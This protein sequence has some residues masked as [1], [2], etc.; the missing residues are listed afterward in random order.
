MK[1]ASPEPLSTFPDGDWMDAEPTH[2]AV[3]TQPVNDATQE[4]DIRVNNFPPGMNGLYPGTDQGSHPRPS[5][6]PDDALP[7]PRP[8]TPE[9]GIGEVD[10]D[11]SPPEIT[12]SPPLPVNPPTFD[13]GFVDSN[14][15]DFNDN[16]N[17]STIQLGGPTPQIPGPS[18]PQDDIS[19]AGSSELGGSPPQHFAGPLPTG[20]SPSRLPSPPSP[21]SY[22]RPSPASPQSD[23]S[24]DAE[25]PSNP[26]GVTKLPNLNGPV[27][28]SSLVDRY[29]APGEEVTGEEEKVGDLDYTPEDEVDYGDSD[30]ETTEEKLPT[31]DD[32]DNMWDSNVAGEDK[33]DTKMNEDSFTGI[34][35]SPF[36]LTASPSPE[37]YNPPY[38]GAPPQTG[39]PDNAQIPMTSPPWV[40]PVIVPSTSPIR[41]DIPHQQPPLKD[42]GYIPPA[43]PNT[44]G[45]SGRPYSQVNAGIRPTDLRPVSDDGM[46]TDEDDT[47]GDADDNANEAGDVNDVAPEADDTDV[48]SEGSENARDRYVE[49]LKLEWRVETLETIF[50]EREA[51]YESSTFQLDKL[52][53]EVAEEKLEKEK[54]LLKYWE[55]VRANLGDDDRGIKYK[56]AYLYSP[57]TELN[58]EIDAEANIR[59]LTFL[60]KKA[61]ENRRGS[62]ELSLQYGMVTGA[63]AATAINTSTSSTTGGNASDG[64]AAPP[65]GGL[66]GLTGVTPGGSF[67][68]D[69]DDSDSEAG[70]SRQQIH[71]ELKANQKENTQE[72]NPDS[73][74]IEGTDEAAI[75][76]D[77]S[78]D[79]HTDPTNESATTPSQPEPE[80]KPMKGTKRRR[81]SDS[82]DENVTAAPS[83]VRATPVSRRGAVPTEA[84][85]EGD[86]RPPPPPPPTTEQIGPS[87]VYTA[88]S[89]TQHRPQ[90]PNP[91]GSPRDQALRRLWLQRQAQVN[92]TYL[93]SYIER[94]RQDYIT[95]DSN[96]DLLFVV[97]AA[98]ELWNEE[99]DAEV[100]MMQER[101]RM[102]DT[103]TFLD[104]ELDEQPVVVVAEVKRR[105]KA[106]EKRIRKKG[107]SGGAKG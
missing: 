45:T 67:T 95:N 26:T 65:T 85:P 63:D 9:S 75:D 50:D 44:T 43:H 38:P 78:K 91:S 3:L 103:G 92:Y 1:D 105:I 60:D 48:R 90:P 23:V 25:D 64:A 56:D 82:D 30:D 52:K 15:D 102:G 31:S 20:N 81:Q 33:S 59:Y 97:T 88:S 99:H 80:I 16:P 39:P 66:A 46:D 79:A 107:G 101:T 84:Q 51:E 61:N 6:V 73:G 34:D 87:T 40:G 104:L 76:R 71:T 13:P 5:H 14:S 100:R 89:S 4:I 35:P 93:S 8:T 27:G 53:Y 62:D 29:A 17:G 18:N 55:T 12:N 72:K 54:S 7:P 21:T 22:M 83:R 41:C 36:D 28:Q 47:G 74:T 77:D 69:A 98:Q 70:K 96:P 86:P 37:L 58:H 11:G 2:V 24:S 106:R 94:A 32:D 10:M 19:E 57:K 42:Q 49:L 68:A